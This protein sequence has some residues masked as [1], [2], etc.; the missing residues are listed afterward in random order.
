[1]FQRK[2]PLTKLWQ[3]GDLFHNSWRYP[4]K[5]GV[6]KIDRLARIL[7]RGIVAPGA[8]ND[9]SVFSDLNLVVAGSSVPYDSLVFLHRFDDRSWLYA[10]SEPGR[11]TVFVD[12]TLEVLTPADMG[13]HWAILSRDEVYV[14]HYVAVDK[15]IGLVVHPADADRV[16]ADFQADFERLNMPVFLGDGTPV[17]PVQ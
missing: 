15:L 11:F 12:A 3:R 10:I 7:Q 2:R 14:R 16:L 17:W 13:K 1:M 8:C 9:G 5:D 6:P 4:R